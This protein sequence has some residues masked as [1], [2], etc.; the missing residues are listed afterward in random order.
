MVSLI[1]LTLNVF[2]CYYR[3]QKLQNYVRTR[4]V[5]RLLSQT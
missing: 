1:E 4:S 2:L 3:M 5:H